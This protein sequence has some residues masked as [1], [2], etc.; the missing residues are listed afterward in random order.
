[1]KVGIEPSASWAGA[2]LWAAGTMWLLPGVQQLRAL[3]MSHRLTCFTSLL[4]LAV[5]SLCVFF[6]FGVWFF[7][8]VCFPPLLFFGFASAKDSH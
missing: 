4:A 1:M 6:W 2:I 7:V 8:V 3:R 5:G